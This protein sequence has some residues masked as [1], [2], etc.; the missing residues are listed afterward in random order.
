MT[1]DLHLDTLWQMTKNGYF[2]LTQG[3]PYSEVNI[4]T[5]QRGQ[6]DSAVFA[7][8]LPRQL[9]YRKDLIDQQ[10]DFFRRNQHLQA[11]VLAMEGGQLLQ[12][13]IE[14]LEKYAKV[15]IVY[16]T[17]T[18]NYDNALGGSATYTN[19]GLTRFGYQVVRKCEE[20]GILVDVS[21][22]SEQTALDV[23]LM[24][25][26]PV[27]ASHSGC[28]ALLDHPRNLTG[29]LIMEI[30][31]TGGLVGVPFVKKFVGT[32]E[33]ITNHIDHIVQLVG[34]DRV[35]IGS[36]IDGATLVDGAGAETWIDV[37]AT[38]LLRRGYK[39]EDIDKVTGGN[40]Q[41]LLQRN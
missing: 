12:G 18:H 5:L 16:L 29:Q 28:R 15:G 30:A 6:L 19:I 20:L 34:I 23:V 35:G 41:R 36:D 26:K 17:L 14:N 33:G 22:A 25:E 40:F 10:I 8:Y 9:D 24:S 37:V 2:G 3:A 11:G 13:K 32:K 7:L 38:P 39:Q 27:I 21:H 31:Q 1:I 4:S